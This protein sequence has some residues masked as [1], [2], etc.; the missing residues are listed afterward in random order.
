MSDPTRSI[1]I[2][3]PAAGRSLAGELA[4]PEEPT[5]LVVFAHGRGSS[6]ASPRD[7]AVASALRD[8]GFATL[9]F[10][11]LT[12]EE[13]EA[14]RAR[15]DLSLLAERLIAAVEWV[16][17]CEHASSLA[18]GLFGASTG[19]AAA[20]SAAAR[21]RNVSAVVSRGGR[22][23]LAIDELPAVECPTLLIVGG[24][25]PEVLS[26]NQFALARLRAPARLHVVTAADHLFEEPRALREVVDVASAWF[27]QHLVGGRARAEPHELWTD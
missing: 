12:P 13:G 18:I 17:R 2:M 24:A 21:L 1:E 15:F 14:D 3:I 5:G 22:P 23:D 26:L 16:E 7:Q 8:D 9:L 25:D 10:D 27:S 20:L 4:L 6:R 19:A 11:L